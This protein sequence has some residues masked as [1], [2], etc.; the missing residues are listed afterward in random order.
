M[1]PVILKL[2]LA[3]S[4]DKSAAGQRNAS[5]IRYITTHGALAPDVAQR[6]ANAAHIVYQATHGAL[7][8]DEGARLIGNAAEAGEEA[9]RREALENQGHQWRWVLSL[10]GDD[11]AAL[12]YKS[13][14]DWHSLAYRVVPILAEEIGIPRQHLRWVAAHHDPQPALGRE[15][16]PHLHIAMWS[17]VPLHR[18][19]RLTKDEL[20]ACR[21]A[22]VQ[23]VH[24]PY[25][26]R[27]TTEKTALREA[28]RITGA[29]TLAEML[30]AARAIGGRAP[31]LVQEDATTLNRML[32][33][34]ARQ[35][36]GHGR[37][38]V[39]YLPASLKNQVY[40]ATDWLLS[41]PQLVKQV[42]RYRV[43]A[44]EL[45]GLYTA[46]PM[47]LAAAETRAYEDL[48]HRVA[49]LLARAAADLN[50]EL[51]LSTVVHANPDS[52]T[53]IRRLLRHIAQ[54]LSRPHY[55]TQPDR[56]GIRDGSSRDGRSSD[57]RGRD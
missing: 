38:A 52:A 11:A 8:D 14:R 57:G 6:E 26:N 34:L 31:H 47:K 36:P 20:R 37:A 40:A 41:R 27:L 28:I 22:V 21:R 15:R 42:S 24:G 3:G 18:P 33:E 10:H 12:G 53:I 50:R 55:E 2:S 30:A 17:A 29:Q 23:L 16:H 51:R 9:A 1:R 44:R 39:A 43:V 56:A 7:F 19:H 5:H 35:M 48:R 13:V 25:R 54:E 45:A 46:D 49:Q 4:A 32:H